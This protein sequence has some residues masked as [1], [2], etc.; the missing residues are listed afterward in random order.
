MECHRRPPG[1][2]ASGRVCA[3]NLKLKVW[4]GKLKYCS[5]L[6]LSYT[7]RTVNGRSTE[8]QL[9][10]KRVELSDQGI[11]GSERVRRRLYCRKINALVHFPSSPPPP[12]PPSSAPPIRRCRNPSSPYPVRKYGTLQLRE[13]RQSNTTGLAGYSNSST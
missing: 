12:P 1:R 11:R 7:Y 3:P 13:R 8:V 2:P 10:I 9:V 6:R 5:V 4:R